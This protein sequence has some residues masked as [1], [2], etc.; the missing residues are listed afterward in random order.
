M[1]R[2]IIKHQS[3]LTT[4]H[5]LHSILVTTHPLKKWPL[6]SQIY[7]QNF[8]QENS[9]TT[10]SFCVERKRKEKELAEKAPR[11]GQG[12]LEYEISMAPTSTILDILNFTQ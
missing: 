8:T 4:W 2:F 3:K 1:Q 12:L 7:V 10:A 5:E 9:V 11:P 6:D